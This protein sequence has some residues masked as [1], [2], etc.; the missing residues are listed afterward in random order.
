M[1]RPGAQE[2]IYIYIN[3]YRSAY[4]TWARAQP[5]VKYVCLCVYIYIYI[6]IYMYILVYHV[7]INVSRITKLSRWGSLLRC[8][9]LPPKLRL[10]TEVDNVP[11][12][13]FVFVTEV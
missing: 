6:Y 12:V 2:Y 11:A 3:L 4:F 8:C 9:C 1:H 10:D 5:H 13:F 7:Y